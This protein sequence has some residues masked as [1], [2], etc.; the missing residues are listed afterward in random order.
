V[1]M[2]WYSWRSRKNRVL[3]T[4]IND[5]SLGST[6]LESRISSIQDLDPIPKWNITASIAAVLTTVAG[7]FIQA[8]IK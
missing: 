4:L 5:A 2:T 1:V 8:F 3:L 6:G 7:P